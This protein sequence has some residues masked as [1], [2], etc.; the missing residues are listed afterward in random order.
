M[1][2]LV[3]LKIEQEVS[4]A[5]ADIRNAHNSVGCNLNSNR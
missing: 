4:S 3:L 5:D 1:E 2:N